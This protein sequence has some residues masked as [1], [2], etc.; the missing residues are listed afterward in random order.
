MVGYYDY[1]KYGRNVLISFINTFNR[2]NQF[3][4]VQGAASFLNRFHTPE[5]YSSFRKHAKWYLRTHFSSLNKKE[6]NLFLREAQHII[7]NEGFDSYSRMIMKRSEL[8]ER[9]KSEN[10][11]KRIYEEKAQRHEDEYLQSLLNTYVNDHVDD[12]FINKNINITESG[13]NVSIRVTLDGSE[14]QVSNMITFIDNRVLKRMNFSDIMKVYYTLDDGSKHY[15][16]INANNVKYLFAKFEDRNW[17]VVTDEIAPSQGSDNLIMHVDYKRITDIEFKIWTPNSTHNYKTRGGSF[18]K[19]TVKS[20]VDLTDFQIISEL[21]KDTVRIIDEHCLVYALHKAG[22]SEAIIDAAKHKIAKCNFKL[23][24]L[25]ELASLFN[26][27]I[28][29]KHY[30]HDDD[31]TPSSHFNTYS[32]PKHKSRSTISGAKAPSKPKSVINLILIDN[33]YMIDRKVRFNKAYYDNKDRIKTFISTMTNRTLA[34]QYHEKRH[35]FRSFNGE[36][37]RF[38]T[39]DAVPYHSIFEV[40]STLRKHHKFSEIN[41]SSYWTLYKSI[42][43]HE[44]MNDESLEEPNEYETRRY[45]PQQVKQEPFDRRIHIVFADFEASTDGSKHHEYCVCA[46]SY[47]VDEIHKR[48]EINSNTVHNKE[49]M[50]SDEYESFE[51]YSPRCAI[52]LLDWI[53]DRSIVYFHNLSYD[54][55]FILSHVDTYKSNII[56][57][58]RDM[59]HSVIYKGKTIIFRDS[60]CMINSKLSSFPSMFQ[61]DSGEK[62]AFPYDY[63]TSTNAFMKNGSITEA[64]KYI[65]PSDRDQ[66]ISNVNSIP[67]VKINDDSFDMEKYALFYCHQDVRILAEGMIK[68]NLMCRSGLGIDCFNTLS[69]SGLANRYFEQHV[70]F[71]SDRIFK[72]GGS[73]R[74]FIMKSIYGGRCMVRDNSMYQ[75]NER[76]VDFDAVSLYPSAIKRAYILEGKPSLIPKEWTS[77][78]LLSHL[79]EDDQVKPTLNR[80]ISG[81]FI[82]IRITKVNRHLHMP[83]I[84]NR[85]DDSLPLSTNEC[86][87]MYVNHITLQDL[88]RY[89]RIEYLLLGG[90]YYHNNRNTTCQDVIQYLFDQRKHFK[91]IHNPIEQTFKLVMNSVYGKTIMKEMNYKHKLIRGDDQFDRYELKNYNHI[92]SVDK[93]FDSDVYQVKLIESLLYDYNLAHFGSIILSMSKRIISEVFC[94]AEEL[95]HMIYYTDTDS[96]HFRES[97][98]S[99]LAD[100]YR[101]RYGRE[102]IG[103]DLGQFHCDF[104]SI[105]RDASMPVSI[106][107]IFLE[108]KS[109]VD[110]LRDDHGN[111]GFHVRMK[112]IPAVTLMNTANQLY[113]SSIKCMIRNGLFIPESNQGVDG[114]YSIFELYK[115]MYE[116]N[117]IAFDLVSDFNPCFEF[118]NDRSIVSKDS[119]IRKVSFQLR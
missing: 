81:F 100:K 84:V 54:I 48:V 53:E 25:D 97:E 3:T 96:G 7:P 39:N 27:R 49:F 37:I 95:N 13:N 103:S 78:Y 60:L 6:M 57:H 86:C 75:L 35:L 44:L 41:T 98:I 80:F 24:D 65:K 68:F 74:K 87:D 34:K 63:Y 90:Y 64:L 4:S 33:H 22:C 71:K 92:Q 42:R 119:F 110:M 73:I 101:E 118:R 45:R 108:K 12:E 112:G 77:S 85:F 62:E 116:G 102:L 76:L 66:F 109:Y 1:L 26:I 105:D 111:I 10:K 15:D 99:E 59:M 70:Y 8:G 82:K 61:L 14:E 20:R 28:N 17:N 58:G 52:D 104:E 30:N 11:W 36:Y 94:L 88:I 32:F 2:T 114:S 55:N 16:Y 23:Q 83:L 106:K 72:V 5:Q 18:F 93:L 29:V 46:R 79:F 9:V 113:P 19:Y 51:S 38:H 56:F 67:D 21:N 40:L 69:I 43:K 115:S 117:E 91:S 50:F 107:S 31:Y 47:S 89:H